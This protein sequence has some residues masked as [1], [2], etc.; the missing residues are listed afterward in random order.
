VTNEDGQK[1]R[2]RVVA[3][4][5]RDEVHVRRTFVEPFASLVDMLCLPSQLHANR[6]FQDVPNDCTRMTVGVSETA[7]G[8][9]D[10]E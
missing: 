4:I 1:A 6:T 10:L 8:I 5:G 3:R 9:R 2:W 7:R